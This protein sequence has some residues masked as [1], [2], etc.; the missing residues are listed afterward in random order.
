MDEID[1]GHK[2]EKKELDHLMDEVETLL[3]ARRKRRE[4]IEKLS[5]TFTEN[6][7]QALQSAV[8]E[9]RKKGLT[10]LGEPRLIDHPAGGGKHALQIP[11]EDWGIIFVP[12][13]GAARP[14]IR[15]EAQI[16]GAAFKEI[17]GRIAVFIG[18]DPDEE[19][20][21]DFLILADGAWFAWGYGWPRQDSTMDNTD[22][23]LLAYALINSFVK[24]I[25]VTWRTRSQTT[26]S[27]AMDARKRV[28]AFGLP[29]D[30]V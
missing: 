1:F 27:S 9:L 5:K 12:L 18:S 15:D 29:G 30:E 14:N 2:A 3:I 7:F 13:S 22:F 10:E 6:L 21:Y 19:S 25:F 28:Y 26:L 11:I 23:T 17:C 4:R 24:D 8:Y 20:F 16:P